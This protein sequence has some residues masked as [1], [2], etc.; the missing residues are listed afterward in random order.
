MMWRCVCAGAFA[1]TLLSSGVAQ[2]A[3]AAVKTPERDPVRVS[4]PPARHLNLKAPVGGSAIH[5]LSGRG[6]F[7]RIHQ[8][9]LS[10]IT[11]VLTTSFKVYDGTA[12]SGETATAA[13][14]L[15]GSDGKLRLAQ[16]LK[17]RKIFFEPAEE[18]TLLDGSS[19]TG[20]SLGLECLDRAVS[21]TTE[22]RNIT[23][24]IGYDIE[25]DGLVTSL[26]A[27]VTCTARFT[28]EGD[29]I[30]KKKEDLVRQMRGLKC[31]RLKKVKNS[32]FTSGFVEVDCTAADC[33]LPEYSGDNWREI[34]EPLSP[35]ALEG[36]LSRQAATE[37]PQEQEAE[38]TQAPGEASDNGDA[39]AAMGGSSSVQ[40]GLVC[41]GVKRM[42]RTEQGQLMVADCMEVDCSSPQY[43]GWEEHEV[44]LPERQVTHLLTT[45]DDSDILTLV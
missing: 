7:I 37:A 33:S 14:P 43:K 28:C 19:D 11:G 2:Q 4:C 25:I 22:K 27:E 3:D 18:V 42:R 6:N 9:Y 12:G 1:L 21:G 29:A 8:S 16:Q 35:A 38:A 17:S 15:P 30:K 13:A 41:R 20:G 31:H 5:T 39:D 44:D 36:I 45:S 23:F 24:A 26:A 10:S 32:P 40:R 34:E